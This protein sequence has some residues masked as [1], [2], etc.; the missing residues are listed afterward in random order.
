[1]EEEN[2]SP[3]G[4]KEIE[5]LREKYVV[6]DEDIKLYKERELLK[7]LYECQD[8]MAGLLDGGVED[9]HYF[10]MEI[11]IKRLENHLSGNSTII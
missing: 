4:R 2:I 10:L 5:R 7:K 9:K 8:E 11:L 6:S 1:M 3:E